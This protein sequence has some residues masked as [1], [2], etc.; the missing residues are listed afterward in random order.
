MAELSNGV[1]RLKEILLKKQT[2]PINYNDHL[3]SSKDILIN[4]FE[5]S[6]HESG[7]LELRK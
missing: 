6:S 2:L 1:K 3:L 4:Q 7:R 5:I